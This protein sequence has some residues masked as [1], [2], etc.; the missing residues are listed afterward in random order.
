MCLCLLLYKTTPSYPLLM[1]ANREERY[2]RPADPPSWLGN[3]PDIFA[4]RDQEAGGTWQ[5]INPS[6]LLVALTNRS[7]DRQDSNRRSRGQLCLDVLRHPSARAAVDWL[8]NH[9]TTHS[10]NPCNLI[11]ADVEEA[12]AIHHDG[13]SAE[14]L[15]IPPGLHF[16][17]DTDLDDP[18]HPRIRHARN[19]VKK[20]ISRDWPDLRHIFERVMAD[21]AQGESPEASICLHGTTGG[22]V[23]SSI[24]ALRKTGL[25]GAEFHFAPGPPCSLLYEDLTARL[26][27][28]T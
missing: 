18:H 3:V 24:T 22:T 1:A 10:Y 14:I 17:T 23:S 6:G 21:H 19:L 28:R 11:C 15:S 25:R 12:F 9:L 5:G 4:G 2:D 16:L 26:H 27:S 13:T 8:Q 20:E 7:G